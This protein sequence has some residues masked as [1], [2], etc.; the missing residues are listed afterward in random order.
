MQEKSRL[1]IAFPV[2]YSI[3]LVEC[4]KEL[5]SALNHEQ[6]KWVAPENLHMTLLFLGDV[7]NSRLDTVCKTMDKS[8]TGRKGFACEVS[9]IG[10]FRDFRNP[11]VIWMGLSPVEPFRSLYQSLAPV[12]E[13][14]GIETGHFKPHITIGRIRK[15]YRKDV[16]KCVV[17]KYH[18]RSLDVFPADRI[19]LYKSVLRQE[20]PEYT[21]VHRVMLGG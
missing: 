2:K 16:L 15:I 5:K 21:P 19:I 12:A 10:V 7:E 8:I 17:E 3:P 11:R 20:G 14:L 18:D 4:L 13:L 9:G 1:F 6:I